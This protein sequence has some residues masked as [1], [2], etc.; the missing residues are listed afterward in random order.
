MT[1]T[2][3]YLNICRQALPPVLIHPGTRP[4]LH[5]VMLLVRLQDYVSSN[6]SL[7][8]CT[9]T[10][11]WKAEQSDF[12]L[13]T[14]RSCNLLLAALADP[15]AATAIILHAGCDAERGMLHNLQVRRAEVLS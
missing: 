4:C 1:V 6:G 3:A 14:M 7:R 5:E 10:Y 9:R 12:G 13:A 11:W 15:S 2:E 8:L